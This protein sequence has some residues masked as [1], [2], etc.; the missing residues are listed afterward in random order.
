[1]EQKKK[2]FKEK[3]D[4]VK[5]GIKDR[6]YRVSDWCRANQEVVVLTVPIAVGGAFELAKTIVKTKSTS[7]E[8]ALKERYIYDR[9]NGHYYECRRKVKNKEWAEIDAR[10]ALTGESV[11]TI[12]QDM[13]LLK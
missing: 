13:R 5:T 3:L 4:D 9:S 7:D 10:H 1:M 11:G 2:T 12:L 6:Y 8:K